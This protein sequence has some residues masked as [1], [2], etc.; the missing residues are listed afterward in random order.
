ME[1]DLLI[2][3]FKVSNIS[4]LFLFLSIMLI[5]VPLYLDKLIIGQF[6]GLE[7]VGLYS[8]CF[9]VVQIG[10]IVNNVLSQKAGPD[11]IKDRIVNKYK[12]L[13]KQLFKWVSVGLILQLMISVVCI[14]A[15]KSGIIH[16]FLPKYDINLEIFMLACLLSIFQFNGLTEFALISLEREKKIFFSNI[17]YCILFLISFT[18]VGYLNLG[19]IFFFCAFI[20]SKIGQLSL[21]FYF[22]NQVKKNELKV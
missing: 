19:L 4:G 16:S 15:L 2:S 7:S 17:F 21:Q 1:R 9:L 14:I 3:V 20:I 10:T 13:N 22:I 12:N 8:V 6:K 5:S 18:V 11:F